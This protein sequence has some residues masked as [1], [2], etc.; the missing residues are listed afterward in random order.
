MSARSV[1]SHQLLQAVD[2]FDSPLL[3]LCSVAL[4][5]CIPVIIFGF[6]ARLVERSLALIRD[7]QSETPTRKDSSRLLEEVHVIQFREA[8]VRRS[9]SCAGLRLFD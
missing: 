3:L 7:R 2:L 4:M 6:P 9:Y 1:C 5:A 8:F